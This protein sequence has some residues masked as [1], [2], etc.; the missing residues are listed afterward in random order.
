MNRLHPPTYTPVEQY[1]TAR[2][3]YEAKNTKKGGPGWDLLSLAGLILPL[4]FAI[5]L[6]HT[7]LKDVRGTGVEI[8]EWVSENRSVIAI[9]VQIISGIFGLI[10]VKAIGMSIT[11]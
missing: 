1:H 9:F 8:V 11:E 10:T 4:G 6:F 5:F 2:P 7:T 3:H